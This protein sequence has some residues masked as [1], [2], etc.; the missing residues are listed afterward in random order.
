MEFVRA[1]HKQHRTDSHRSD[2]DLPQLL[3]TN[4]TLVPGKSSPSAD[5][6]WQ[7]GLCVHTL[8]EHPVLFSTTGA[9]HS[10]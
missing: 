10:L 7:A 8:S 9:K 5:S 2:A 6:F 1:V 3:E 4:Y